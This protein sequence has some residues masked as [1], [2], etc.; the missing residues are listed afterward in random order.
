MKETP[1]DMD[2]LPLITSQ[3]DTM[4][5]HLSEYSFPNLYLFRHIH[6][7]RILDTGN[8]VMISGLSY[9]KKRYIMPLCP[10]GAGTPGCFEKLRELLTDQRWDFIFPIPEEWLDRF[11]E[12]HFRYESMPGDSDYLF[13]TEKFKTYP[14]KSMHRKKNQLN[15]YLRSYESLLLPLTPDIAGEARDILDIW[16][17]SSGQNSDENDY[18][19]CREAIEK[20]RELSL[21]GAMA[22]ADGRP[23]GFI[24][25]EPLNSDTFTIH[26]AKAD[27]RFKGIY[28]FLFSRFACDFCP[29]YTYLNLEQDLGS[30]GLRK[31][32][33]S[34]RPD[35]MA[36]KYR[37]Y[38]K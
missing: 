32:K 34:Y 3:L 11:P 28:Q 6:E 27:I 38:L 33:V 10:P 15:Q 18:Y 23:A 5:M 16:Q 2:S 31:T 17:Q 29:D 13:L 36:H 21:S 20:C 12:E 37:I 7:Y 4:G 8:T 19:P 24:L 26:F 35:L 14:G 22:C 1:L 25:G 30:E 9:D